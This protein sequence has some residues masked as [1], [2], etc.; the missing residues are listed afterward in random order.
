MAKNRLNDKLDVHD[1][2]MADQIFR[3]EET[4]NIARRM[5]EKKRKYDDLV[6]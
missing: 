3:K 5:E 6:E 2:W 1:I 4:A